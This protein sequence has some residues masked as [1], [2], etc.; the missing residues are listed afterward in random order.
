[1]PRTKRR[2]SPGAGG[3]PGS[4]AAA[5]LLLVAALLLAPDAAAKQ[6]DEVKARGLLR[7]GLAEPESGLA[8][9]G[10]DGA[11]SGFDV[12]LCRALAAGILGDAGKLSLV[13]LEAPQ[14]F[15]ALQEDR[16][17]LIARLPAGR[18]SLADSRVGRFVVPLLVD[19]QGFLVARAR[20]LGNP[21]AL[22]GERICIA[23]DRARRSALEELARHRAISF[24]VAGFAGAETAAKAFFAGDCA[25]L[26]DGRIA[27]ARLRAS[28]VPG[29]ADYEILP[30]ILRPE[31]AGPFVRAE[32][33]DWLEL[34]RWAVF[35]LIEAEE[36]GITSDRVAQIRDSTSDPAV[37]RLL[38]LE[39]DIGA[40]LGLA[41]DWVAR[42]VAQVGN[43]GEL[44]R[45]SLGAG[46]PLALQRGP[47]A[48]WRDGGLLQAMPFQ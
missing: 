42:M 32:A 38:G 29:A 40:T 15:P 25:A 24:E 41:P 48:L 26:S 19:G 35:A 7:C 2:L 43:Y 39:G 3:K 22:A 8:E 18:A 6:L 30:D 23:E 10:P 17:D 46:S 45:R 12:E 31:P 1:M 20:H 5:T 36:R 44:Y 28:L 34:V 27:L 33:A 11:W 9:Q 14:V 37:R 47:N 21:L 16:V 13:A 4:S